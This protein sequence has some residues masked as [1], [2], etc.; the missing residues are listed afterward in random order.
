MR[1]VL[2]NQQ[3]AA[4]ILFTVLL[5]I[6]TAVGIT[7]YHWSEDLDAKERLIEHV[8]F[9]FGDENV[10]ETDDRIF[11]DTSDLELDYDTCKSELRAAKM[12]IDESDFSTDTLRGESVG[13]I[14]D[15][16]R[17]DYDGNIVV[18]K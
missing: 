10:V 2:N 7:G 12:R 5:Y 17:C 8:T 15:S 18:F 4:F 13:S 14:L 9:S 3:G 1:S 6:V 11:I 16:I